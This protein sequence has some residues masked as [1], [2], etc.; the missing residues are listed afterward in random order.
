[1]KFC[2]DHWTRLR[3]KIDAAGLGS[4]VSEG[5][6][7]AA[8][9]M[10]RAATEGPSVDAF[11]P[12]M[13][14]HMAIVANAVK[15]AGPMILADNDDGTPRCPVC[16]LDYAHRVGC[17]GPPCTLPRFGAFDYMLDRAVA[18]AV[19]KWKELGQ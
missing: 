17:E 9:T 15:L 16:F 10:V 14:A 12:L 13:D 3:E 1:M 19:D 18:D 5:G 11:D 6:E 7:A 2:A 4:L 8:R